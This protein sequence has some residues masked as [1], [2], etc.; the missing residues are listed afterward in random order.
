MAL[1]EAKDFPDFRRALWSAPA[2]N[3]LIGHSEG[4]HERY[5]I[6]DPQIL[7]PGE[8]DDR[9]HMFF[10]GNKGGFSKEEWSYTHCISADGIRWAVEQEWPWVSGPAYLTRI[11]HEWVLFYTAIP[12]VDS[13]EREKYDADTIIRAKKTTDF[14][15]WSSPT[16]ILVPEFPWEREGRMIEIRNP[17]VVKLANGYRMYYSA[18]SVWLND[19]DYEEPKYIGCAES[20]NL[21]GPYIKRENPLLSPDK[22]LPYCNMGAGAIKVYRYGERF[23]ALYNPIYK[24]NEGRSRSEI[25]V[26][27]SNDG[28]SWTEAP[29][30]PVVAPGTE[31]WTKAIIYQL[32]L[33]QYGNELRLYFN[34]RDGWSDGVERIGCLSMPWHG[35]KIEKMW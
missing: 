7:L 3:P 10:Q 27:M 14:Q 35:D 13:T 11:D 18:G 28:L 32:D 19:C 20:D 9:W 23:L 26:L 30:N 16:D 6:G 12:A 22:E 2:E 33:R 15:S 8:L 21:F 25:R 17:C 4:I 29:Y 1:I 24:D 34:A 5:V 31:D